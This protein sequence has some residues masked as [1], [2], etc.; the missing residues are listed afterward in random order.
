[1]LSGGRSLRAP[2]AVA[3]HWPHGP[4]PPAAS[5]YTRP[6]PLDPTAP[7]RFRPDRVPG[8]RRRANRRD[9]PGLQSDLGRAR[10]H[11]RRHG[12]DRSG[13]Y[14]YE[15]L[16]P[17]L[18]RVFTAIGP[19]LAGSGRG[20]RE[21]L[22]GRECHPLRR[23]PLRPQS[24]SRA[25]RSAAV[26]PPGHARG[27]CLGRPARRY[28]RPPPAR[29]S[30]SPR[31][32]P[33]WPTRD[34][35]DGHGDHRRRWFWRLL[36]YGWL[37]RPT[38][39]RSLLLGSIGGRRAALQVLRV[40]LSPRGRRGDRLR[41]LARA[42]QCP[43]RAAREPHDEGFGWRTSRR[44]SPSGRAT[45]LRSGPWYPPSP[46]PGERASREGALDRLAAAPVFPAPALFEGVGQ[47]AAKN[48]AG[49]K[50]YLLGEVR[51]TGWWYFFPVALGGQDSTRVHPARRGRG[52]CR[53]SGPRRVGPAPTARAT[54]NRDRDPAGL[55]SEPDQHRPASRAAASILS[56]RSRRLGL[57]GL[58][59]SDGRCPRGES[60]RSPAAGLAP[61]RVRP[62]RIRTTWPTSTSWRASTRS[63][64]WWTAI[65]TADRT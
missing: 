1:M 58:M 50:S 14:T 34:R 6:R 47:L 64:S 33:F 4:P 19:R 63:E 49:H 54:G 39:P 31:F 51:D 28:C 62:A 21:R 48:R 11:R 30:C 61:G 56:L 29:C 2:V 37:D 25:A 27:V 15:P 45:D 52:D 35:H 40:A 22:A 26:L 53:R 17:P 44:C 65:W 12:V 41:A 7:P 23:R 16:H 3:L 42:G 43:E 60:R 57:V 18:A 20:P 59:R 10:P 38:I 55:P 36:R 32:P 46:A 8:H 24:R 13:T 5:E 9:L